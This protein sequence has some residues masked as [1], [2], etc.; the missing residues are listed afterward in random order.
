MPLAIFDIDGTL[1]DSRRIISRSMDM[2][3]EAEGLPAPGYEV[4]RTIV[5]MSLKLAIDKIAPRGVDAG[6]LDR[7]AAA[8]TD[9]YIELRKNPETQAPLYDGAYAL[10]ETLK[11]QGW[12]MGVATGK[13]RKGLDIVLEMK[14]LTPFFG[15]HYCADDGPSKPDPFMVEANLNAL[16]CPPQEAVM[17]G[18]TSFDILMGINASVT[19]LGVDWGFHTRKELEGCGANRVLS[20]MEGLGGA[21]MQF[22]EQGRL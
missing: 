3:F 5:G 10:L 4:T 18:D 20:T 2:A 13:S 9:A 21:L 8:Y 12:Q 19:T 15:A 1:V 11:A 7:L 17:I 16:S 14:N 6:G 22:A